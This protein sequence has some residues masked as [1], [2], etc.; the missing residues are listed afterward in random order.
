MNLED[1]MSKKPNRKVVG[2]IGEQ[3]ARMYVEQQGFRVLGQNWR[4]RRGE[5]D[6]ILEHQQ[7]IIFV[8]VRTRIA[9]EMDNKM[10]G[11]G[12]PQESINLRKQQKVRDVALHYIQYRG[13]HDRNLQFDAICVLLNPDL[14]LQS[15]EH[16]QHAF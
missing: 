2:R 9:A 3:Q 8:E 14:S 1:R 7:S 6:L 15:L 12:S 11:F 13:Y 5:L 16:I 10:L 4:C